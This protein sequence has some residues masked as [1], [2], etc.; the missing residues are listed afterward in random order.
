MISLC[1]VGPRVVHTYF[2]CQTSIEVYPKSDTAKLLT[3]PQVFHCRH[4]NKGLT[5]GEVKIKSSSSLAYTLCLQLPK[6]YRK[7]DQSFPY[8]NTFLFL[9]SWFLQVVAWFSSSLGVLMIFTPLRMHWLIW[10]YLK[11]LQRYLTKT[12][13]S[14]SIET[15][16]WRQLE[17]VVNSLSSWGQS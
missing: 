7:C 16:W 10:L 1:H 4:L 11:S 15:F 6:S 13:L 5:E 2:G 3:K 9:Q 8:F 14:T 17:C 12:K